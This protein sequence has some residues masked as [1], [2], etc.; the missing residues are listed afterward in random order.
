MLGLY[1]HIPFCKRKC[2]Y[3]DFV[4][5]EYNEKLANSY[6][7]ALEIESKKYKNE[8]ID[9]IY[10]GGGTPSVLSVKQ[11]ENLISI[12]KSNFD[13][14][15]LQE[16]AIELNPESTTKEKLEFLFS[17]G[18][19]RLSFGLQSVF[20]NSLNVLGRLHNYEKFKQS[21]HC[22][23]EVGFN[24]I[25]IDLIYGIPNQ[26]LDDWQ[27]TLQE[28]SNLNLQHISLY[29]LTVEYGTPFYEKKVELNTD[30]QAKMYEFACNFLKENNFKHY[31]I[32]NWAKD[33]NYSKHNK[34]YWQNKEYIGLGASASSYYKRYRYKN[35]ANVV[36]YIDNIFANK[37]VVT[38]KEYITDDLYNK[39]TIMLGLRLCE[40]VD[41]KYFENSKD[42][43]NKYV[44]SKMLVIE[45]NK[46]RFTQKALFVSNSILADF[47]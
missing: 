16:F 28:V 1:V 44:D 20:D 38:E 42:V 18:I 22:A 19:T 15:N 17:I 47:V 46:V 34:L 13:I 11:L 45:N 10:I 43:L 21:Y 14:S 25:N 3:C 36:N 29:P 27:K 31:E 6:I 37:N 4:S 23:K 12:I 9:T 7:K 41:I 40:G 5:V 8:K 24:N 26:T 35:N 39:E 30:L 2:F 32:S 33:D